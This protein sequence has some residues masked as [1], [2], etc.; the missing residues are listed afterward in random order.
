MRLFRVLG[1]LLL[2]DDELRL[3]DKL[4]RERRQE[5]RVWVARIACA[6][7]VAL[8]GLGIN[9]LVGLILAVLALSGKRPRLLAYGCLFGA[10]LGAALVIYG[11]AAGSSLYAVLL[12]YGVS[13]ALFTAGLVLVLTTGVT[14]GGHSL[15]LRGLRREH[16]VEGL[17]GQL[18]ASDPVTRAK[19]VD[20]LASL[21]DPRAE[22]PLLQ[23]LSDRDLDVRA[24]AARG[25]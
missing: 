7:G 23:A 20:M 17:I 2:G 22:Q 16:D 15:A 4:R 6:L 8:I 21:A 9:W 14:L 5:P 18:N 1:G 11:V 12:V 10:V 13:T 19:A 25:L 24:N 3:L